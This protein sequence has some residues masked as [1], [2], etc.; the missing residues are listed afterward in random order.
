MPHS[1]FVAQVVGVGW[2]MAS[3]TLTGRSGA[4]NSFTG[5]VLHRLLLAFDCP[6][7]VLF[8]LW[9]PDSR[10]QDIWRNDFAFCNFTEELE[11]SDVSGWGEVDGPVG[12]LRCSRG[13]RK[14]EPPHSLHVLPLAFLSHPVNS[15]DSE[16]SE[17]WGPSRTASWNGDGAEAPSLQPVLWLLRVR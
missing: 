16:F 15:L 14:T 10:S 3:H 8:P 4:I 9:G 2:G 13:Q 5:K 6:P 12:I 7:E 17:V 1:L 11:C